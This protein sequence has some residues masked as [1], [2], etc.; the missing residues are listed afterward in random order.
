V[1]IC[2]CSS[3]R[4]KL[5]P[6]PEATIL[7]LSGRQRTTCRAHAVAPGHQPGIGAVAHAQA[8]AEVRALRW[9]S[10]AAAVEPAASTS[11]AVDGQEQ[12]MKT[13]A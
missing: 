8:A 3:V 7:Q 1:I 13:D 6:L 5:D 4:V 12:T 2:A 11:S 10:L 9:P